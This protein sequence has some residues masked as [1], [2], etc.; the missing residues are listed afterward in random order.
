MRHVFHVQIGIGRMGE[1][2]MQ[3]F[4]VVMVHGKRLAEW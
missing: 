2:R 4:A 1:Y 3:D